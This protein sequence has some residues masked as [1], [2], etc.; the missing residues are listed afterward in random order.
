MAQSI[1]GGLEES[2]EDRRVE[3][4]P[5]TRHLLLPQR[6]DSPGRSCPGEATS[7]GLQSDGAPCPFK[8]SRACDGGQKIRSDRRS[9]RPSEEGHGGPDCDRF[10][11]GR[12]IGIG[13]QGDDLPDF[14]SRAL[15]M[16]I[17]SWGRFSGCA[18]LGASELGQAKFGLP[19]SRSSIRRKSLELWGL[20]AQDSEL[21]R[22]KRRIEGLKQGDWI[23]RGQYDKEG[24][25]Q[26]RG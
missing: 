18:T 10:S 14:G 8:E 23:P 6:P 3:G 9:A 25:E 7:S 13:C 22:W 20:T 1:R 17:A 11:H 2:T 15:R 26:S 24:Q 19:A 21:S 12:N 4:L 5:E 16:E